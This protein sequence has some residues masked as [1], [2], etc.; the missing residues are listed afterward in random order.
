[1]R[2]KRRVTFLLLAAS[3]LLASRADDG[4]RLKAIGEAGGYVSKVAGGLEVGFHHSGRDLNDDG[5]AVVAGLE[6]LVSLNLRD[7][8]I[9]GLGLAH[10]KGLKNLRRL[11]LE[12]TKID[13][14][15]AQH[16]AGLKKL[17]YLNLYSTDITDATL[18]RLGGLKNLKQ[19][20]VW[21]T[22]VTDEGC[23]QLGAAL[24][25]LRISRGVDLDRVLAEAKKEAGKPVVLVDLKWI[26]AGGGAPPKSK[27]GDF[28]TVDIINQRDRPVKLYWVQY[29]G[30]LKFYAEIGAGKTLRRN[31]YSDAVWVIKDED[32]SSLGHFVATLKPSRVVIPKG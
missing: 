7:T 13:D 12:R 29:G 8:Q 25:G 28:T 32:D 19:L 16:L 20:Y 30:G 10:L 11:H 18:A 31:T 4:D 14:E 6:N 9:S 17:E 3:L 22:G 21:Q 2:I 24:P 5:V 23:G 26:P 1:M 27:T 15:G